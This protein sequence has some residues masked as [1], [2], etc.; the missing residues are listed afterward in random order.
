[1]SIL[2]EIKQEGSVRDYYNAF[3]SHHDAFICSTRNLEIVNELVKGRTK[4]SF[5]HTSCVKDSWEVIDEHVS[6]MGI[7]KVCETNVILENQDKK[8]D[9][10]VKWNEEGRDLVNGV[11]GMEVDSGGNGY[12][13][14]D[15][16]DVDDVGINLSKEDANRNFDEEVKN[17]KECD[18]SPL[19]EMITEV[20]KNKNLV[21]LSEEVDK[22]NKSALLHAST[23]VEKI[24]DAGVKSVSHD[25][26]V[27]E[28][29][30]EDDE[31]LKQQKKKKGAVSKMAEWF[32]RVKSHIQNGSFDS[33]GYEICKLDRKNEMG[34]RGCFGAFGSN[35]KN[36]M[37]AR[38][39]WIDDPKDALGTR[40]LE[41]ELFIPETCSNVVQT[42]KGYY[43]LEKY[44]EWRYFKGWEDGQNRSQ[45]TTSRGTKDKRN[46]EILTHGLKTEQA[47]QLIRSHVPYVSTILPDVS[48]KKR[49]VDEVGVSC[50]FCVNGLGGI[51]GIFED[52]GDFMRIKE[53]DG[54]WSCADILTFACVTLRL[55]WRQLLEV[56]GVVR[57]RGC[58]PKSVPDQTSG[59][60]RTR[61]YSGNQGDG[62]IDGQG[63][64]VGDQGKGQRTGR[65]QNNDAINDNIRGDIK[66]MESVQDMSGCRD[67]QK[68]KYTAGSFVG[69]AFTWWNSQIHTRGQEATVG[70][71]AAMKPMTIQKAVQI[72]DTLTDEALRNGSIKKNPEKRRNGGE[73]NKDRNV[74]DDNKRTGAKN[75]YA[76]TENPVRGGYTGTAPKCTTCSYHHSPETPCRSCFNCDHL[77]HFA[78][79]CRVAPRYV[80]PINARNL[81]ARTCYECG[82]TN[83][84]KSAY[85]RFNQAQRLRG[86]HQNQVVAVNKGQG[87]RNQRNQARGKAFMLGSE[88]AHQDSNI[89]TGTFILNDHYATTLFNSGANYSFVST[90]FIPLLDIEPSN[91]GFSYEIEI[92]SGQLLEIDKVIRGCKLEIEGHVFDINLIPFGSE[93]FDVIIGMDW[94]F[95]HKAEIIFHEKV[96]RIPLLDGKIKFRIKLIPRATPVAKSLYRLAPSELEEL[97]DNSRNSKTKGEEQENTFQTLKDKLCNAPVLALPD[98]PEDFV[99]YCD[100]SILGLGCELMQRGKVIAYASR[101]L[102]IHEKNYTTHDLEL[103]VVI[104]ALKIWRHYLCGKKSVMYMDHKS[105]QHIFSQKELN[106]RQRLWIELFSGYDCEIRYHPGK[107]NVVADTLSRNERVKPKRVRAINMTL[108]SNI[109]DRI[110]VA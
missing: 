56:L 74:R 79:D 73:P 50:T 65:N 11:A 55:L 43:L 54:L 52:D 94:L 39:V 84:I 45:S 21:R 66:E 101:Q 41:H 100:A 58:D 2:K 70:M 77:G 83:H 85:P 23:I 72:A 9:D 51:D 90:T 29:I 34:A 99:V 86:N 108:Q 78:K 6:L 63:G 33:P 22:D 93:G 71:V 62:R 38:G 107:A 42:E 96:V 37:G 35:R 25:Q 36:E 26:E 15:V 1:M 75:A 59:D 87:C 48:I 68:V 98:G 12:S 110:L 8:V 14:F 109:K 30:N 105:L 16:I 46:L 88:E 5:T 40:Q 60:A 31:L 89:M 44:H 13:N 104:L 4:T 95:D 24:K 61:G 17:S 80:N 67:S 103:G 18:G 7:D 10:G 91:L 102:K 76:T 20:A 82:S 49:I 57:H 27:L 106:M 81:V 47:I 3:I 32:I 28:S 92:S 64:Q 19:M 97:Q 69:K 53:F